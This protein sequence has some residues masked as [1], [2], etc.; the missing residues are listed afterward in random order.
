MSL[1]P[2]LAGT[3][4]ELKGERALQQTAHESNGASM[5]EAEMDRVLRDFRSSVHAWSEAVYTRPRQLS[6]M[7]PR[8]AAWRKAAAWCL[9]CV[10]AT[11]V[12]G[13]GFLELQ[14]RQEVARI[15]AAREAQHQRDLTEARARAAE[16]E[17]A[18]VDGD[19][20]REVP[21]AMEPLA[22][23]MAEDESQ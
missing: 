11:G 17:L 14:H 10:L 8:R 5:D 21:N 16:E 15:A 12:A 9:G 7:A 6:D 4:G 23:L 22:Q 20:A 18:K 2:K 19:I 13:G 1:D 3:T